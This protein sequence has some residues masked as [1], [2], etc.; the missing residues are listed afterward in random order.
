MKERW[1]WLSP[2]LSASVMRLWPDRSQINSSKN[3][4][5]CGRYVL[6]YFLTLR[7]EHIEHRTWPINVAS[8]LYNGLSDQVHV[9]LVRGFTSAGSSRMY[10]VLTSCPDSFLT[11]VWLHMQKQWRTRWSQTEVRSTILWPVKPQHVSFSFRALL[12]EYKCFLLFSCVLVLWQMFYPRVIVNDAQAA[13]WASFELVI[14]LITLPSHADILTGAAAVCDMD[15]EESHF[16]VRS[17]CRTPLLVWGIFSSELRFFQQFPSGLWVFMS[18]CQSGSNSITSFWFLVELWN[19]NFAHTSFECSRGS[20]KL[21]FFS[22][23]PLLH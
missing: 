8:I 14:H 4:P 17:Q 1:R 2:P 16:G 20:M 18:W 22:F 21:A 6:G 5:G 9:E 13:S 12:H 23:S 3:R 11:L 19:A 10:T 7:S 15:A